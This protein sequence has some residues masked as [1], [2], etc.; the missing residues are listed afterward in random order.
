MSPHFSYTS[1]HHS[2]FP[3]KDNLRQL[4]KPRVE[5]MRRDR[6]NTCIDQLKLLLETEL[7]QQEPNAKLEK[8]DVLEMT[9][10]FLRRQLMHTPGGL[11]LLS[12]V[13]PSRETSVSAA[14]PPPPSPSSSLHGLRHQE[15]Q[16]ELLLLAQRDFTSSSSSIVSSSI[17]ST[18]RPTGSSKSLVW[19]PW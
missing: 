19:R 16:G 1:V 6:I 14:P 7:H 12:S 15:H 11:D 10:C 13:G 2:G 8:A 4:R 5:K 3:E 17:S 9:V 18:H